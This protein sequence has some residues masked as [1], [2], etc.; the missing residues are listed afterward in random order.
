MKIVGYAKRRNRLYLWI[1][2]LWAGALDW[3]E[4]FYGPD[5]KE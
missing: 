1:G 2:L 4:G 3:L 5:S